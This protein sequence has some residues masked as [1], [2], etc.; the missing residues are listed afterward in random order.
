VQTRKAIFKQETQNFYTTLHQLR[1]NLLVQVTAL[2]NAELLPP[3]APKDLGN[4]I[5]NGLG[6]LDVGYLNSRAR[7][8]GV[9]KEGELVAE[10]RRLLEGMAKGKENGD[11]KDD[12]MEE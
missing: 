12:Q 2:E 7:D 3:E 11:S 1:S 10:T 9:V 4:G 8:V 5:T 6:T